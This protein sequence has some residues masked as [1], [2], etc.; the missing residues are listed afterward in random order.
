VPPDLERVPDAGTPLAGFPVIAE[1]G[2]GRQSTS[3]E[4]K[5]DRTLRGRFSRAGDEEHPSLH[6]P[7][8]A[9]AQIAAQVRIDGLARS[10]PPGS[11][12]AGELLPS[13]DGMNRKEVQGLHLMMSSITANI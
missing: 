12:R 5:V 10:L 9:S 8:P 1:D 13:E 4:K 7:D 6:P 2:V 11:H 3:Y